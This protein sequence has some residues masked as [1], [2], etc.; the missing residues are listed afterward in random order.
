MGGDVTRPTFE[1]MVRL[2]VAGALTPEEYA[3]LESPACLERYVNTLEDLRAGA[4]YKLRPGRRSDLTQAQIDELFDLRRAASDILGRVKPLLRGRNRA[5]MECENPRVL[6]AELH[7][8]RA[9]IRNHRRASRELELE[10]E[11]HDRELWGHVT[12]ETSRGTK[13]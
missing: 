2:A 1:Q 3:H 6:R 8:L 11:P 5:L 9:A 7:R 4:S 10:P 12:A 13:S